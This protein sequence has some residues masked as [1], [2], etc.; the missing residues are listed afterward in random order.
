MIRKHCN[1]RNAL[2]MSP[3]TQCVS[4]LF[5]LGMAGAQ[6]APLLSCD[7]YVDVSERAL[8][9]DL[10]FVAKGCNYKSQSQRGSTPEAG[11]IGDDLVEDAGQLI[12]SHK[13]HKA[14]EQLHKA[15]AAGNARALS[16]LGTMHF[17]P[18]DGVRQDRPLAI[19]YWWQA[20]DLGE[21]EAQHNLG[22]LCASRQIGLKALEEVKNSALAAYVLLESAFKL[23]RTATGVY[24]DALL[25]TMSANEIAQGKSLYAAY[26]RGEIKPSKLYEELTN[27]TN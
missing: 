20:A 15:A 25:R 7:H 16:L 23:G 8:K 5:C 10:Y 1:V 19:K 21:A 18:F 6:A 24:M 27:T 12:R 14:M 11:R 3:F 26:E 13:S 9:E 17:K 2:N 22:V 4:L